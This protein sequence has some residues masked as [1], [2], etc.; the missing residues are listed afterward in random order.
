M[1]TVRR[2]PRLCIPRLIGCNQICRQRLVEC[3]LYSDIVRRC[4]AG[5]IGE[6]PEIIKIVS[7]VGVYRLCLRGS[8]GQR[9]AA[10][11]DE[12]SVEVS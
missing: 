1:H 7:G 10:D 12:Q 4:Q 3:Q 9:E 8:S 6:H 11:E 5:G 2:S